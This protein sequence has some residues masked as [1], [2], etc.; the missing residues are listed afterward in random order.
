MEQLIRTLEAR[1]E[2]WRKR[3]QEVRE[4]ER[5][6]LRHEREL[7]KGLPDTHAISLYLSMIQIKKRTTNSQSEG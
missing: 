2:R 6:A 1:N 5:E 7:A 3:E 4:Y